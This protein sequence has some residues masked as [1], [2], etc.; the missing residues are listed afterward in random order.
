MIFSSFEIKVVEDFRKMYKWIPS[1]KLSIFLLVTLLKFV[2][3]NFYFCVGKSE[4]KYRDGSLNIAT[5]SLFL[6]IT[7]FIWKIE[8]QFGAFVASLQK[9]YLSKYLRD[10][11]N[12][13]VFNSFP[14]LCSIGQRKNRRNK[15]NG[16]INVVLISLH[17]ITKHTFLD[18]TEHALATRAWRYLHYKHDEAT[19]TNNKAKSKWRNSKGSPRSTKVLHLTKEKG[20]LQSRYLKKAR[21]VAFVFFEVKCFR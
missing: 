4:L 10:T 7:L 12:Q 21:L 14:L 19:T 18:Y 2:G 11:F 8:C 17:L 20:S 3:W 15:E 5:P 1:L 13:K 6:P 16:L 9:K